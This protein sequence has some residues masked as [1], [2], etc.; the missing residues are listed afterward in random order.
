M[1]IDVLCKWKRAV[2]RAAADLLFP[3][4]ILDMAQMTECVASSISRWHGCKAEYY[5][6]SCS[7][8]SDLRWRDDRRRGP[9]VYFSEAATNK[10]LPQ[11]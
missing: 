7:T 9:G 3:Y 6:L 8:H 10:L 1:Y 11:A 2:N 5:L 4:L